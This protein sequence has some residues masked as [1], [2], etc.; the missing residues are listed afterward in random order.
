MLGIEIAK[1]GDK[2]SGFSKR[3]KSLG[4]EVDLTEF[5]SGEVRIGHTQDRKDEIGAVLGDIL[6][7]QMV[8]LLSRRNHSGAE[9][10]GLSHSLLGELPT[11]R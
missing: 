8:T 6:K 3:F 2:A 9:C 7:E 5:S 4:V 1:E 10:T 11:V